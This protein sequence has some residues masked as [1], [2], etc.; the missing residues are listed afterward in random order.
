MRDV[1]KGAPAAATELTYGADPEAAREAAGT[2]LK[3]PALGI[4][5]K[6]PGGTNVGVLARPITA[7]GRAA[8]LIPPRA[9][10]QPPSVSQQAVEAA[11]R[12]GYTLPPMSPPKAP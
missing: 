4:G 10:C 6:G 9:E 3:P 1:I 7:E 12:G 2:M 8:P 5:F 11:A